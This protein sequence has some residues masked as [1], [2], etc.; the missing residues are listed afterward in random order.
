MT[1]GVVS[2]QVI[3][4]SFEARDLKLGREV[5]LDEIYRLKMVSQA[6]DQLKVSK[7]LHYFDQH[8]DTLNFTGALK[9][10]HGSIQHL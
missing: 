5:H 2:T 7:I 4:L 6:S 9:R 1:G 3:T 8:F 10:L